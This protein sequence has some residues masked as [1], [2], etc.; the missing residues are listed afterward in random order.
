MVFEY[1]VYCG[2]VL[3]CYHSIHSASASATVASASAS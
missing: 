2:V 1:T 3:P